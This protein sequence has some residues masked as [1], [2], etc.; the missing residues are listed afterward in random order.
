MKPLLV[1]ECV[2]LS[3]FCPWTSVVSLDDNLG[4]GALNLLEELN[5]DAGVEVHL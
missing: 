5:G 2:F 1:R 3:P 4:G